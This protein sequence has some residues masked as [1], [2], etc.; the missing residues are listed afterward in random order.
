MD[1]IL[2]NIWQNATCSR[3]DIAKILLIWHLTTITHLLT[4]VSSHEH[5]W[6]TIFFTWTCLKHYFLHM[7]MLEALFSSHEHAWSTIFFTWTWALLINLLFKC[8]AIII[9]IIC[10]ISTLESLL[11]INHHVDKTVL[12]R[13]NY[14]QEVGNK[15]A[16]RLQGFLTY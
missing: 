9:L 14:W 5:A 8:Q 13:L 11:T 2:I 1:S 7:N 6:S 16:T 4:H 10:C 15:K 3:H 12:L